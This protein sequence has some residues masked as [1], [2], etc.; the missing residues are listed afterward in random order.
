MNSTAYE[1]MIDDPTT[2]S[3]ICKDLIKEK[4]EFIA[5]RAEIEV[6]PFLKKLADLNVRG[7]ARLFWLKVLICTQSR[8]LKDAHKKVK[9]LKRLLMFAKPAAKKEYV[10]KEY[11]KQIPIVDLYPFEK[12]RRFGKRYQCKCPFHD[13]KNPSF[14][15]YPNNSFY[16]FSCQT[17][18]DSITFLRRLK[19]I[20][21]KEAV[22][23]IGGFGNG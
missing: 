4:E 12:L 17:G 6:I 8:E 21:F 11:A 16:C 15:I 10:N 9:E 5:E 13:E 18:G 23:E 2:I 1:L 22:A 7:F 19:N 14:V 20:G 3:Q